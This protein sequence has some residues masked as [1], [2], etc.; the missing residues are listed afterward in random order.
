MTTFT[1]TPRES[2]AKQIADAVWNAKTADYT[3]S[4]SF[5]VWVKKL[6]SVAKFLGLQ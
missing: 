6:L 3:T 2:N 1:W 5:G 4:G